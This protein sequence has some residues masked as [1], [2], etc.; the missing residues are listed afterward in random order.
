MDKKIIKRNKTKDDHNIKISDFIFS[1]KN[2]NNNYNNILKTT[3]HNKTFSLFPIS[4]NNKN[5]TLVSLK[6]INGAYLKT[7]ENEIKSYFDKKLKYPVSSFNKI[8][9]KLKHFNRNQNLTERKSNKKIYNYNIKTNYNKI[10]LVKPSSN[11]SYKFFDNKKVFPVKNFESKK[12]LKK[13][14]IELNNILIPRNNI[15]VKNPFPSEDNRKIKIHNLLNDI[16]IDRQNNSYFHKYFKI[17]KKYILKSSDKSNSNLPHSDMR[18]L[19]NKTLKNNYLKGTLD[20]ITRDVTYLNQKNNTISNKKIINLLKTEKNKLSQTLKYL[21]IKSYRNN[22]KNGKNDVGTQIILDKKDK[23]A[24]K[25]D[26]KD[27]LTDYSDSSYSRKNA[28]INNNLKTT[29]GDLNLD[30]LDDYDKLGIGRLDNLNLLIKK[31]M[32][33][34]GK[35]VNKT[36]KEFEQNEYDD[37][38]NAKVDTNI[39]KILALKNN[40]YITNNKKIVYRNFNINTEE[41]IDSENLDNSRKCRSKSVPT[42]LSLRLKHKILNIFDKNYAPKKLLD[43]NNKYLHIVYLDLDGV[44]N[45]PCYEN[46]KKIKDEKI[47]NQ[48]Y[49]IQK[50]KEKM[51]NKKNISHINNFGNTKNTY[52][53]QNSFNMNDNRHSDKELKNNLI[54]IDNKTIHKNNNNTKD[55]SNLKIKINIDDKNSK[56][57]YSFNI[58]NYKHLS[59][60]DY[61]KDNLEKKEELNNDIKSVNEKEDN[62]EDEEENKELND[63]LNSDEDDKSKKGNNQ[64]DKIKKQIEKA[65]LY[66]V[67]FLKKKNISINNKEILYNLLLNKNFK[68][69][70]DYLKNKLIQNEEVINNLGI[71]SFTKIINEDNI[72]NYLYD[73]FTDETSPYYVV[74]SNTEDYVKNA[75]WNNISQYKNFD[76][77][78]KLLEIEEKKEKQRKLKKLALYN[79]K[80]SSEMK[81]LQLKSEQNRM[82]K[83]F[84]KKK[85]IKNKNIDNQEKKGLCFNIFKDI[86]EDDKKNAALKELSLTNELKYQIKMANDDESKERFKYLLQ[87]IQRL[88]TFDMNEYISSIKE[89]YNHYRGEI[90][91][92]VHAK[93]MEERINNFVESLSMQ[94]EK[95]IISRNT[96]EK[97]LSIKDGIFQTNIID[98]KGNHN[99]FIIHNNNS[100][101]DKKK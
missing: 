18:L 72:I 50:E 75:D 51:I 27:S 69:G 24:H 29:M 46:G 37:Y 44:E 88:K 76:N 85:K 31:F 7:A 33:K 20:N 43:K 98:L 90:N 100:I 73:I 10:K 45:V 52:Y 15:K 67:L 28:V 84:I 87:E 21:N 95:N 96:M 48:I 34:K 56:K 53:K 8:S 77:I 54:N 26:N 59:K 89:D 94:R 19:K 55:I 13:I 71:L 39:K 6:T 17:N 101:E 86:D 49:L 65:L 93:E 5:K 70:V 4:I 68:K 83:V 64:Q 1:K 74:F 78:F 80:L 91:D 38:I 99:K 16:N 79:K 11:I 35:K 62:I 61:N 14:D 82:K 63:I 66:F 9:F 40:L 58:N 97:K 12:Y 42:I 32:T 47:L 22:S 57:N 2:T 25:D 36:V 60:T 81:I 41:N 23:K 92:L 30:Y 3:L